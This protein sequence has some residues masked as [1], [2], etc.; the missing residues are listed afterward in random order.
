MSLLLRRCVSR[1]LGEP[2]GQNL[3]ETDTAYCNETQI[4]YNL[5][6]QAQVETR[7]A[8]SDVTLPVLHEPAQP[9]VVLVKVFEFQFRD[10]GLADRFCP[11]APMA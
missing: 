7:A 1:H 11:P 9:R 8:R 5:V 4:C 10:G 3:R 2:I 6:T